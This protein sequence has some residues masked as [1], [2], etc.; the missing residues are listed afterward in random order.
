M[1]PGPALP[2]W[3][4][5]VAVFDLETTGVDV[6]TD[7]VVSAHVGVLDA[8]GWEIAARSWLADPGVPI[9]EGATAVHGITT[10]FAAGNGRPAREVVAEVTA[11]LRSLLVQ[12]VPVVA[13]NAAY[14]FSLLAH[15]AARHGIEPLVDPSPVIDPLIIDKAY[16]R[17]RR[18][19]RTLEVVAE[20]YAVPLEGAHEASADAI[21]AGRVAQALARQFSLPPTLTE[22]HTRQIGWAR[23]QAASLTEYFVSIGRLEPEETLD[24]SWPVRPSPPTGSH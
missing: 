3:L 18:G 9:P 14:D 7:R 19:K 6:T 4:T 23:S 16:D 15:E 20:H 22:L 21:A 13:Y 24:G 5:R 1:S 17:Y 8:D 11:A 12:G 10:E 2:A